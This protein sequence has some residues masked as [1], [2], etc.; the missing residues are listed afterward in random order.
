MD[1]MI[2]IAILSMILPLEKKTAQIQILSCSDDKSFRVW[3]SDKL[4]LA[5]VDPQSDMTPSSCDYACNGSYIVIG[6]KN[7]WI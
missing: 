6:Y 7:G 5:K 3:S 4:I 1:H 2:H